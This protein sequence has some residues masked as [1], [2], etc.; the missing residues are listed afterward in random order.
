MAKKKKPE[1]PAP[2]PEG[3]PTDYREGYPE[4]LEDHMG[5]GY[6]Y[7]A[8]CGRVGVC[9]Q[10]LYTWE[11]KYP[12]FLDAKNRGLE[13]GRMFWERLGLGGAAGAI[14]NFNAAVWIFTM[15]NRFGWRDRHEIDATIK[16]EPTVVTLPLA[17]QKLIATTAK[18]QVVGELAPGTEGEAK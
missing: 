4:L 14:K 13:K 17:G 15:K 16:F 7:E 8:F 12:E 6:T 5:Q 11:Q 3:R 2:R 9:K 1:P 10:T 18:D